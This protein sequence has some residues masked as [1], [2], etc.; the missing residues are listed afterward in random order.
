MTIP[1]LCIL[2]GAYLVGTIPFGL[3]L[4][5]AVRGVDIRQT[6]SG[7]IG[8][9]NAAR[10]LGWKWFP[11]VFALDLLKGAGPVLA[12]R[13]WLAADGRWEPGPWVVGAGLCAILGHAF[14]VW[15]RFRG[16]KAVAT[17]TGVFLILCPWVVLAGFAVWAALFAAFR[18]V[19]LA[20]IFAALA[21]PLAVSLGAVP[22]PWGRGIFLTGFCWAGAVLVIILHRA[23]IRRLL[24]GDERR[25]GRK[26][27]AAQPPAAGPAHKET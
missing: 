10:V 24:N 8:A 1:P 12:A 15:L 11:I 21:L 7:N 13:A 2:A 19:S 22:A 25:V 17:S 9:T 26:R 6:G 4:A 27:P 3:L 16:G 5:R 18:Y 23:N 20:S 14:P